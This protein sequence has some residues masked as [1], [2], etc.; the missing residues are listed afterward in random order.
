MPSWCLRSRVTR[1]RAR[2]RYG[3]V[4]AV[5]RA[6][7]HTAAMGDLL[8]S[9]VNA[10]GGLFTGI[11]EIVGTAVKGAVDAVTSIV[12]GGAL[13]V[14]VIGVIVLVAVLIVRR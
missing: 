6:P 4:I 10:L 14:V 5:W 13:P 1:V 9:V 2:E 3:R 8:G 12:P 11:L 7:G